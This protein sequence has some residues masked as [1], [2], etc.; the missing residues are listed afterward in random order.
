MSIG[1]STVLYLFVFLLTCYFTYMA[2]KKLDIGRKRLAFYFSLAAVIIPSLLA[3]V[4]DD[5]VGKDVLQYA[6]RTFNYAEMSTSFEQMRSLSKEP[7]GYT[8][9]AYITSRFFKDTGAF[10]FASQLFVAAPVYIAAYKTRKKRP[11]WLTMCSYMFLFYNNSFNIMKQSVSSAFI[12]LCYCYIKEKKYVKAAICFGI[13]FSFHFSAVFGLLF[14]LLARFVKNKND[15]K[16]KI[17][18]AAL[19]VFVMIFL[20][21]ISMFLIN[22][23][24]LPEKY[25]RNITAVFDLDQIVYL[26]IVGF[27]MHVFMDWIFR[28]LLVVVPLSLAK[29]A[30]RNIDVY[31]RIITVIGL[32]FYTYVLFAFRTVYGG[33]ISIYCDFFLIMLVPAATKVFRKDTFRDRL[34]VNSLVVGFMG[35]YWFLWVMIFG[36]S[37]SNYFKFRF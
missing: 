8:L 34:I 6:V 29:K 37:A 2:D 3:G 27:N 18:L 24:F 30:G 5:T 10:L 15:K 21:D 32:V 12:L 17:M 16:S 23:S 14:I 20:K 31:V 11:M 33:R 4:R 1:E 13:A 28:V 9:L 26:R 36:W 22:N 25:T 35:L 19:F 7:I